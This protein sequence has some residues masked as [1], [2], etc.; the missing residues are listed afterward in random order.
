MSGEFRDLDEFLDDRLSLPIRGRVYVVEPVDAAT[1][2]RFQ[3]MLAAGVTIAAGGRLTDKD[4]D[5]VLD[6]QG[7]RNLYEQALGAAYQQM[8]DDG[9]SWPRITLAGIT[10][11]LF[12]AAG[13]ELAQAYWESGGQSMGEAVAPNRAG[14][15]A[16]TRSTSTG[17]A[18]TTQQRASTSGT[19]SKKA[20]SRN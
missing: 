16:A 8:L 4:L 6:D 5:P 17:G 1:G 15:R 18:S 9:V 2:L 3:A 10:A 7:E 11:F 14:R 12:A 13:T 19:R 20:G